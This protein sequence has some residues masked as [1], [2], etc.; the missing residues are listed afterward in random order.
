MGQIQ[1]VSSGISG[2]DGGEMWGFGN[3][4]YKEVEV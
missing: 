2:V 3:G 1:S 4:E